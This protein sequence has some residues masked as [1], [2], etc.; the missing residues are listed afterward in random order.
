MNIFKG[1]GKPKAVKKEEEIFHYMAH[2]DSAYEE[3]KD[4]CERYGDG[5]KLAQAV[6]KLCKFMQDDSNEKG[7]QQSAEHQVIAGRLL[8]SSIL[9]ERIAQTEEQVTDILDWII[10]QDLD[11][12]KTYLKSLNAIPADE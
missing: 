9:I 10:G 2:L 8:V 11:S 7:I 4:I 12:F 3:L 6:M 5:Q 1:F